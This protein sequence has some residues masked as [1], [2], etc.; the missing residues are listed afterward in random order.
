VSPRCVASAQVAR[1]PHIAPIELWAPDEPFR[2]IRGVSFHSL[3]L[4]R[5][6]KEVEPPVRGRT[7]Q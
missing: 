6:V 2:P 7:R 5:R 4:K 3:N 1:Q